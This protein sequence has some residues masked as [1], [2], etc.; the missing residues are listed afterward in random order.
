MLELRKDTNNGQIQ[1]APLEQ[2]SKQNVHLG[3][4]VYDLFHFNEL[5]PIKT[6]TI[7]TRSKHVLLYDIGLPFY[8][9]MTLG[10]SP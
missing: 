6:L 2:A 4:I 3:I 10:P 9:F 8:S 7:N 1:E 5:L